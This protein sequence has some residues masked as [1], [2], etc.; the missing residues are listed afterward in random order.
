MDRRTQNAAAALENANRLTINDVM[1]GIDGVLQNRTGDMDPTAAKL[2]KN[3]YLDSVERKLQ[4]DGKEA[5]VLSNFAAAN[6]DLLSNGKNRIQQS[7]LEDNQ[8]LFGRT[9]GT[10]EQRLT[11][12]LEINQQAIENSHHEGRFLGLGDKTGIDRERLTRFDEKERDHV[13]SQNV[14]KSCFMA[15][16]PQQLNLAE[17]T[18]GKFYFTKNDLE[19]WCNGVYPKEQLSVS[20]LQAIQYMNDN[21]KKMSCRCNYFGSGTRAINFES[22]ER[23]L[24]RNPGNALT[25]DIPSFGRLSR[26][27]NSASID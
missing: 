27:S 3:M 17:L 13:Q 25:N 5:S 22:A 15:S 20:Q 21:F 2:Y 7:D 8:N 23:Y 26:S 19:N 10:L 18:G 24:Q 6:F 11:Q 12:N 4:A 14:I 16:E 1:K 9:N